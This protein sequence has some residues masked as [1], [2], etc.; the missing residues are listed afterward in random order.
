MDKSII[1][2]QLFDATSSTFTY[3]LAEPRTREAVLI[4]PVFEQHQ[5]DRVLLE[6]LNLKLL[7]T[8][9]THCH[10]DHVTG[11]WLIK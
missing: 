11:V 10:T 8:L 5:R 1:F 2:R 7:C 3:L 9:D 4:D 6:E